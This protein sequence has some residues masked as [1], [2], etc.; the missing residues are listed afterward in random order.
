MATVVKRGK[1][2]VDGIV[3]SI[4]VVVYPL[5]QSGKLTQNFEEEVGKDVKGFDA[6]WLARNEHYL[7]D[8]GFKIVGDTLANAK[9]G[10]VFLAPFATVTLSGFD[11]TTFNGAYQNV[12]GAD[13]DLSNVKVGELALKL[14][15]YTDA[16]QNTAATTTP[17]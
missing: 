12:S 10:G 11:L 4:D 7:A 3:G 2:T 9:A 14:R 13:I 15:R 17:S 16:A 6:W 8:F 5:Q 1:A